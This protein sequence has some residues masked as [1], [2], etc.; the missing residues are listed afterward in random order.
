MRSPERPPQGEPQDPSD[1]A[2]ARRQGN[3]EAAQWTSGPDGQR[4]RII[5]SSEAFRR[6]DLKPKLTEPGQET[7]GRHLVPAVNMP[8]AEALVAIM[9][10][11]LVVVD[12]STPV[13]GLSARQIGRK[14]KA[15]AEAAGR[16]DGFTGHSGR[17]SMAQDLADTGAELPA[18]MT[19]DRWKNSRMPAR[20]T[21]GQAA[22]RGAV[23]RYYQRR[24]G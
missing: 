11:E 12:P 2:L 9:S 5:E 24:G 21:E 19:A 13:F 17:V 6:G 10:E 3:G 15:S 20:Y 16:G 8:I 22:G 4:C 18:Q 14:V 7:L 1:R 23:A